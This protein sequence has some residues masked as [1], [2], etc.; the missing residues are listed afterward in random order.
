MESKH[1]IEDRVLKE[2]GTKYSNGLVKLLKETFKVKRE[3]SGEITGVKSTREMDMLLEIDKNYLVNVEFQ[4]SISNLRNDLIRF[5]YYSASTMMSYKKDV[6]T[7]I[8]YSA[9]FKIQEV[10]CSGEFGEFKT[11][12]IFLC[13]ISLNKELD[14]IEAYYKEH[15]MITEYDKIILILSTGLQY[16]GNRS[17]LIHRS[18]K[19]VNRLNDK[20]LVGS[21]LLELASKFLD[22]PD[23][24]EI[25]GEINMVDIVRDIKEKATREGREEAIKQSIE[26]VLDVLTDIQISERFKI[27][28]ERVKKIRKFSEEK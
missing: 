23:Y 6:K 22:K 4:S 9:K 16:I 1:K 19:I 17:E 21:L 25:E 2:V 10:E 12:P 11:T 28:I 15:N 7:F 8:I 3:L 24:R 14:R 18:V 5:R 13:E 20:E 27:S 26:L